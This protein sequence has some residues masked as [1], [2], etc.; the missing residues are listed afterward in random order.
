[1]REPPPRLAVRK[2][3]PMNAADCDEARPDQT[4]EQ[5]QNALRFTDG[6]SFILDTPP[7]PEPLWGRGE[8]VLWAEG[9]A[10]TIVGG[11]G[12]GKTTLAQQLALGRCGIPEYADVLGYP[13]RWRQ[14]GVVLY[15][16]MDRPRQAAR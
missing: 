1:M 3:G 13:V 14:C 9:E 16:A 2:R 6:G 12:V 5:P 11:Q 4:V 15:M 8:A 10:L 7:N